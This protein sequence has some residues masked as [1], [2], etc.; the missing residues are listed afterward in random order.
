MRRQVSES[1][2]IELV[3]GRGVVLVDAG[4]YE[5]L[6]RHRWQMMHGY[7]GRKVKGATVL[8]HRE[9]LGLTDRATKVDHKNHNGL[10][11]RRSNLRPC[12][13][14]E[15]MRNSRIRRNKIH[16]RYKGVSRYKSTGRWVAFLRGRY[17]GSFSSEIE[18]ARTYDAAAIE[19][20]G[21]FAHPNFPER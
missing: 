13:H 10:D 7:A 19:Q 2:T 6:S 4:D 18:A 9:I 21:E 16:S 8:M 14:S 1:R 11:N 12:S 5:S 17:L 3:N 20:Y 15:N